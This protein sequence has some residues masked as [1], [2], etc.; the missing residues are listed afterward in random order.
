MSLET[1]NVAQLEDYWTYYDNV[2]PGNVIERSV[3]TSEM[4]LWSEI[5]DGLH[6]RHYRLGRFRAERP[7]VLWSI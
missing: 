4:P 5:C 1:I 7:W 2:A 6:W 3:S